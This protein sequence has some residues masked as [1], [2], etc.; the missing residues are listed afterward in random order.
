M[1][2]QLEDELLALD[3][4]FGP[5]IVRGTL[6]NGLEIG[7]PA[8]EATLAMRL[9]LAFPADYPA[10]S[11]PVILELHSDLLSATE[12]ADLAH[13]MEAMFVPGEVICWAWVA[14]LQEEWE[15]RA[16]PEEALPKEVAPPL[17]DAPEEALAVDPREADIDSELAARIVHGTPLTEK[18]S[19]FQAHVAEVHDV[20]AVQAVVDHLLTNN[21]V[22]AASHNIMAYRI[23]RAGA[24]GNF[25]QDCDDDG[26]AAAGSRLLH[27]LQMV[28]ARNVVVVVSRW[29]GGVLL[30]P[31][32]FGLINKAARECLD[33]CGFI[34]AKDKPGG[35]SSRK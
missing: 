3:S 26:E 12:T 7:V 33:E 28:D 19:T 14:F 25:L 15:R 30:G 31:A 20:A 29:F 27:L 5:E 11:A 6:L 24:P 9:R 34:P 13:Q 4:I 17:D 10:A 8:L 18:K 21:K 32:R 23:E 22:R 16:P 35:G 1:Q 2:Q